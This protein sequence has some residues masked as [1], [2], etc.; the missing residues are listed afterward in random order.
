MVGPENAAAPHLVLVTH[1]GA[2]G[3]VMT[4]YAHVAKEAC[5]QGWRCTVI[6]PDGPGHTKVD[7]GDARVF[8]PARLDERAVEILERVTAD[9]WLVVAS[10]SP[11]TTPLLPWLCAMPR[12]I[13]TSLG[14]PDLMEK[15]LGPTRLD[16]FTAALAAHHH[17]QVAIPGWNF[18]DGTCTVY[19]IEPQRCHWIPHCIEPVV[20]TPLPRSERRGD[21]VLAPGRL[22]PERRPFIMAAADLASEA[23]R[24]LVVAGVGEDS[25]WLHDYLVGRGD[26]RFRITEDPTIELLL[27]TADVAVAVGL[28]ALEAVASGCIV[29][30]PHLLA[31]GGIAG[32]I[33][34]AAS[35]TNAHQDHNFCGFAEVEVISPA[36]A[37]NLIDQVSDACVQALAS[38]AREVASPVASLQALVAAATR[39]HGRSHEIGL[40]KAQARLAMEVEY[41]FDDLREWTAQVTDARDWWRARYELAV[42]GSLPE[43][44]DPS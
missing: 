25:P 24:T 18:L 9:A 6:A 17:V 41:E 44:G 39:C 42:G 7:W 21:E 36:T 30:V 5:R 32:V 27:R 13:L 23:N 1:D 22:S 20:G 37:W 43:P 16:A 29:V 15:W 40:A 3:G 38:Q 34:D 2:I 19:A 8:R 4:R 31:E 12:C 14:S 10:V 35:L 28:T 11:E 26:V 33:H